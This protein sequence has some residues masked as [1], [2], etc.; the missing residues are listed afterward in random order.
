MD[1]PVNLI[2]LG[3]EFQCS[4]HQAHHDGHIKRDEFII[5]VAARE[6]LGQEY[7]RDTLLMLHGRC[8]DKLCMCPEELVIRVGRDAWICSGCGKAKERK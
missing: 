2:A 1:V 8:R 3:R 6:G 7:V 4:C 5:A